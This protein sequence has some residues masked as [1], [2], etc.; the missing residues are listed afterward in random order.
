MSVLIG[1]VSQVSDLAPWLL[2]SLLKS[3]D[4]II[5]FNDIFIAKKN[6]EVEY[7]QNKSDIAI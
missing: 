5:H 7:L 2:F 4:P 1:T 6:Q 3:L